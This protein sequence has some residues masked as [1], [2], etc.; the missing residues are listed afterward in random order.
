MKQKNLPAKNSAKKYMLQFYALT[1]WTKFVT[2]IGL[3][4]YEQ[5][6]LLEKWFFRF[7]L[8]ITNC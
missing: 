6:I 8:F 3:V 7:Q 4:I 2:A 1:N 5:P